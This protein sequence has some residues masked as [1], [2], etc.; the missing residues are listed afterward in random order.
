MIIGLFFVNA[1]RMVPTPACATIRRAFEKKFS[2]SDGGISPTVLMFCG[3]YFPFSVWATI[4]SFNRDAISSIILINLSNG[5]CV[6]I[7]QKIMVASLSDDAPRVFYRRTAKMLPLCVNMVDVQFNRHFSTETE[8]AGVGKGVY[9]YG[10]SEK[11]I[12]SDNQYQ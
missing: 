8:L 6:P 3:L 7:V 9:P 4:S 5:A 12:F 11:K 10:F 2:N 1:E